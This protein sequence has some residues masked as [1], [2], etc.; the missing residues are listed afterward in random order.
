[1]RVRTLADLRPMMARD[2]SEGG[3][4][5]EG[6]DGKIGDVLEIAFEAEELPGIKFRAEVEVVRVIAGPPPAIGTRFVKFLEGG[7]ALAQLVKFLLSPGQ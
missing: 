6:A 2:L 5:L 3:I 7:T 4:L 1:M